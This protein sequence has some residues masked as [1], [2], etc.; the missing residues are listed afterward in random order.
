MGDTHITGRHIGGGT[1]ITSDMCAGIHI[2]QGYTYHC[3]SG[4][5]VKCLTTHLD[6]DVS[7]SMSSN[8]EWKEDNQLENI[9]VKTY[10]SSTG[11]ATEFEAKIN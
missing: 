11:I 8:S 4:R 2:S 3:D 7:N 5:V 6:I 1:H 9:Y 10:L